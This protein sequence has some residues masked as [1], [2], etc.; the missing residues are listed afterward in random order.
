MS[1]SMVHALIRMMRLFRVMV[2]IR[3]LAVID[4]SVLVVHRFHVMII[5]EV[6]DVV[7]VMVYQVR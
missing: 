5:R 3:I 1:I 4:R 2:L 6:L 7:G